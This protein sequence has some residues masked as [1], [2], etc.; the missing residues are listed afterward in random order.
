MLIGAI[1]NTESYFG[2]QRFRDSLE[3]DGTSN[4]KNGCGTFHPA[5]VSVTCVASSIHERANGNV[6]DP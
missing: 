1:S 2:G 5:I 3:R 6:T 4:V